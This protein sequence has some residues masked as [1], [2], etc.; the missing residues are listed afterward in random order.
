[1][2]THASVADPYPLDPDPFDPDP[3][4]TDPLDPDVFGPPFPHRW[5]AH[6]EKPPWD[7]EPGIE[8]GPA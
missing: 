7:A 8:L 4:D 1:L 6:W 3:L 2:R 5:A